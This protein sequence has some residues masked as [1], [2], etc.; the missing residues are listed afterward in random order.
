MNTRQLWE[1]HKEDARNAAV[2]EC[3]AKFLASE[4]QLKQAHKRIGELERQVEKLATL[5]GGLTE[6]VDKMAEWAKGLKK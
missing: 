5:L 3:L 2:V 1:E 4:A 6:R